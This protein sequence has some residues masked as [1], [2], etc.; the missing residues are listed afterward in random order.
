MSV[1]GT[2]KRRVRE[3]GVREGGQKIQRD[4]RRERIKR[5]W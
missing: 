3:V 1:E 4:E 2:C 5:L